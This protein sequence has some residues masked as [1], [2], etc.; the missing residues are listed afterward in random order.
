MLDLHQTVLD[1]RQ[2]LI[3]QNE[4]RIQKA[5]LRL[6]QRRFHVLVESLPCL[7]CHLDHEQRFRF[8]NRAYGHALG[9]SVRNVLG[10]YLWEVI[11]GSNYDAMRPGIVRAF[12]GEEVTCELNFPQQKDRH[13]YCKFVPELND[14]SVI[15]IL[16]MLLDISDRKAIERQLTQSEQKF[17][18]IAD[19]RAEAGQSFERSVSGHRLA[20]TAN[21]DDVDSGL[22]QSDE[23]EEDR[24]RSHGSGRTSHRKECEKSSQ[25]DR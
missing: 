25:R 24:C 4:Q 3:Q 17:R 12:Q 18:Q 6:S 14:G 22:G 13:F 15:G 8:C 1:Q 10:K 21:A 5:N 23:P 19:E 2:Q 11:G 16:I 20:R 9:V 7:I